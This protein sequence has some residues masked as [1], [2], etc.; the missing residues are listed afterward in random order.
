MLLATVVLWQPVTTTL[1]C[2][3]ASDKLRGLLTRC[4]CC[5]HLMHAQYCAELKNVMQGHDHIVHKSPQSC[6]CPAVVYGT[7]DALLLT[8]YISLCI[9]QS[10]LC[11]LQLALNYTPVAVT[12]VS[13]A[14]TTANV[15]NTTG[16]VY[17]PQSL[18]RFVGECPDTPHPKRLH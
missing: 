8:T 17:T 15:T 7:H 10:F 1:L 3:A 6:A 12:R 9:L 4:C 13:D 16:T 18:S 5:P 2:T 11:T 14:S